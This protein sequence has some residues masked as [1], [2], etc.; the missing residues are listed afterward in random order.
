MN[1]QADRVAVDVDPIVGEQ[2]RKSIG[3]ITDVEPKAIALNRVAQR[4]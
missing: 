2:R 3:A 4:G 1:Y